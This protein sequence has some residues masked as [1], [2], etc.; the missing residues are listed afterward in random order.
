MFAV[1]VGG[2]FGK[3]SIDGLAT[4]AAFQAQRLQ[5]EV[6]ALSLRSDELTAQVSRLE[7]PEHVRRVAQE[8]G[9]VPAREPAYLFSGGQPS[10]APPGATT[11]SS[12]SG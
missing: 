7:S 1:V 2:L 10:V 3:L 12:D 8:L 6:D 11:P 9:M 4:E 5:A